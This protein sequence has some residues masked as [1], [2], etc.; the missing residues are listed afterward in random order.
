MNKGFTLIEILIAVAIV[1]ILS[2]IALPMYSSYMARGKLVDA[3]SA[4]TTGRMQLEQYFQDHRSYVGGAC[5]VTTAYFSY[6]CTLSSN[7]DYF[8]ITASSVA[9]Q[10]LGGVAS[11]VYTIDSDNAKTTSK[12]AGTASTAACWISKSGQTC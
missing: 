9:G 1:G 12:F 8:K 6:S 3:Q 11:Y 7:P 5:P 10:G 4:L 2:A